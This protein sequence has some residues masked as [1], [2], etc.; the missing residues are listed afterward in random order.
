MV[1]VFGNNNERFSPAHKLSISGRE[2]YETRE[3]AANFFGLASLLVI[4]SA[5]GNT[6]ARSS[7]GDCCDGSIDHAQQSQRFS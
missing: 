6:S 1:E 7:E 2:G 5:D 4:V 3:Y